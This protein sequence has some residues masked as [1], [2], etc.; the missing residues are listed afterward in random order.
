MFIY[1]K[2]SCEAS[3]VE[4]LYQRLLFLGELLH[5]HMWEEEEMYNVLLMAKVSFNTS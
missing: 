4:W 3:M 1:F 2:D 5:E